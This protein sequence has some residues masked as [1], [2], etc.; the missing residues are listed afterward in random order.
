MTVWHIVI[1]YLPLMSIYQ[2]PGGFERAANG[3]C[4]L[5]RISQF[6]I[7]QKYFVASASK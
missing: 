4:M 1:V 2:N 6:S 5:S 3:M 7:V